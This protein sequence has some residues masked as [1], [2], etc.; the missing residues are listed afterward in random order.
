MATSS[1]Q[2]IQKILNEEDRNARREF[3]AEK[4]QGAGCQGLMEV[5]G[6]EDD[7]DYYESQPARQDRM[8]SRAKPFGRLPFHPSMIQRTRKHGGPQFRE[9]ARDVLVTLV[10]YLNRD[11]KKINSVQKYDIDDNEATPENMVVYHKKKKAIY[12]IDGYTT[13]VGFGNSEQKHQRY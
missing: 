13:A 9:K 5:D 6:M 12:S 2:Q 10:S 11:I 4:S 1:E 7:Y 3:E 8:R